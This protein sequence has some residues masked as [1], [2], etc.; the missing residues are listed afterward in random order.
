MEVHIR[1]SVGDVRHPIN[2]LTNKNDDREIKLPGR[3]SRQPSAVG[4]ELHG[5]MTPNK[6]SARK[7]VA[8][9]VKIRH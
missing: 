1:C 9:N 5:K 7:S 4:G 8:W 3:S 6:G 2:S